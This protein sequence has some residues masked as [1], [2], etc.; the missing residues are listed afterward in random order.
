MR[1]QPKH[2]PGHA[3]RKARRYANDIR[4]LRAEGHTYETIRLALLD[5]GVSL[6]HSTVLREANR[7]PS[8]WEL[9]NA[10]AEQAAS[11][12]APGSGSVSQAVE[13]TTAPPSGSTSGS[14]VEPVAKTSGSRRRVGWL[15]GLIG[16]LRRL[17]RA[18][19]VT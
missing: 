5:A 12:D 4:D 9:A 13:A 1:L 6:S 15:S 14:A 10:Q 18:G 17:R 16:V 8:Q 3:N 2:P 11:Q 19:S 7:P